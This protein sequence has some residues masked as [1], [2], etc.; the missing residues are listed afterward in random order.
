MERFHSWAQF[1]KLHKKRHVD[2]LSILLSSFCK[3]TF[4]KFEHFSFYNQGQ[5]PW[6]DWRSLRTKTFLDFYYWIWRQKL[7]SPTLAIPSKNCMWANFG[8]FISIL[9][10]EQ[11]VFAS[12]YSASLVSRIIEL[13][14]TLSSSFVV[15]TLPNWGANILRRDLNYFG[16]IVPLNSSDLQTNFNIYCLYHC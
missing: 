7:S 11:L 4:E 13:V 16:A 15:V 9:D 6:T 12:N 14:A 2:S 10:L 5:T 8:D 3:S 1:G